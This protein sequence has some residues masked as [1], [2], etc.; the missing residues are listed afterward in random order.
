[1][2]NING[3]VTLQH[4]LIC[5]I[6]FTNNNP[7]CMFHVLVHFHFVCIVRLMCR[8]IFYMFNQTLWH[9]KNWFGQS[10]FHIVT[11]IDYFHM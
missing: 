1:L 8:L 9:I 3:S 6:S 2:F 5:N 7:I 4:I 10:V 11:F